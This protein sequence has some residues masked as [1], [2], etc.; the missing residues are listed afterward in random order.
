VADDDMQTRVSRAEWRLEALETSQQRQDSRMAAL[1]DRM[2]THHREVMGAIGSLRDDRARFE[3]ASEARLLYAQK[4]RDRMKAA[5]LILGIIATLAALGWINTSDAAWLPVDMV[6]DPP[7]PVQHI[8]EV[9][10]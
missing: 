8:E 2:E 3:G 5:S 6:T 4:A 9:V 10:P 1:A 7:I